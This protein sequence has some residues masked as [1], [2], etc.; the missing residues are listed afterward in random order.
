MSI[1]QD[2]RMYNSLPISEIY[3]KNIITIF[4]VN[5][6]TEEGCPHSG[7]IHVELTK[8]DR[9]LTDSTRSTSTYA[10]CWRQWLYRRRSE[11][12]LPSSFS[13]HPS[14]KPLEFLSATMYYHQHQLWPT[15]Q[16][17]KSKIK[18]K[19]LGQLKSANKLIAMVVSHNRTWQSWSQDC[20]GA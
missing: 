17:S 1:F 4:R 16:D 18:I 3:K 12:W 2:L 19:I 7:E 8:G 15:S 13:L 9:W 20:P 5:T 14:L 11:W 10:P 6:M